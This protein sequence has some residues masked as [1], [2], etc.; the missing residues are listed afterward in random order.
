MNS[1]AKTI[2]TA[3]D[4]GIA[5]AASSETIRAMPKETS[6]S[7][8]LGDYTLPLKEKLSYA[9]GDTAQNIVFAI[10]TSVL[11]FFY[12]DYIGVSAGVV[13]TIILVSRFFDGASDLVM[14]VICDKTK[15]RHGKARPW[16]LWMT[17][18]FALSTVALFL[19]PAHASNWIKAVY[20]FVT[21]NLVTTV[22]YTA[23]NLPYS[24]MAAMMTRNQHER[25]VT[26]ALRMSLSPMGRIAATACTI[27]WSSSS[28]TTSGHGSS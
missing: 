5:G 28:G 8:I 6:E 2:A 10:C 17:L 20:I 25:G 18:P 3:D 19:I 27:P 4:G 1:T 24:A 9:V 11:A 26:N 22:V 23:I 16:V 12:T 13:G 7:K 21:Y 15:S 14:G